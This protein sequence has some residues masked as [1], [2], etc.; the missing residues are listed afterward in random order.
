MK[1]IVQ[2]EQAAKKAESQ[3]N[4]VGPLLTAGAP[5]RTPEFDSGLMYCFHNVAA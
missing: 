1:S 4:P 2:P 5:N 3:G